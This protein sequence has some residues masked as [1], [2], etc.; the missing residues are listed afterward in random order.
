M[1]SIVID[2]YRLQSANPNFL[3]SSERIVTR[4]G[5]PSDSDSR[6]VQSGLGFSATT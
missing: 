3:L 1:S 5:A 2:M 4:V 6:V